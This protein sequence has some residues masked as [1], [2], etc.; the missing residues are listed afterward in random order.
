MIKE[1]IKVYKIN[2]VIM[3]KI[4][5]IFNIFIKFWQIFIKFDKYW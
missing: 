2:T 3:M 5:I 1:L 4:F